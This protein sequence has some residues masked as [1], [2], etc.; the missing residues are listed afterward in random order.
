VI[1]RLAALLRDIDIEVMPAVLLV[2][3]GL[4]LLQ[5]IGD[6]RA[7]QLAELDRQIAERRTELDELDR[8][9][10]AARQ[11]LDQ[12]QAYPASEDLTPLPRPE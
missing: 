9:T 6:G 1:R 7:G 10:A 2:T 4:A 11:L 12:G 5:S 8:G 3:A